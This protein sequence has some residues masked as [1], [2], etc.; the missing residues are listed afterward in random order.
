MEKTR[1]CIFGGSITE[2]HLDLEQ[3]G[4]VERLKRNLNAPNK[5]LR[6]FNLGVSAE[7]TQE[8]LKRIAKESKVRQANVI[9]F[10]GGTNDSRFLKGNENNTFTKLPKFEKNLQ[11]IYK[12]SKRLKAKLI[13]AGASPC[14]DTK[15]Q[16][17]PWDTNHSYSNKQINLY[18]QT[19]EKFCKKNNLPFI[20][21]NSEITL[22]DISDDGLHPNPQGHE[23]IF[24]LVKQKLE[25]SKII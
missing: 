8:I 15:T 11:K 24:R 3:G 14:D 20:E 12:I 21:F 23:K 17:V 10:A 7:S 22:E 9:I 5:T 19:T 13:F 1:I 6:I 25:E 18:N 4:W 16:P 2:G